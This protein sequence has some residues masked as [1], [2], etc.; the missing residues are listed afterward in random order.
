VSRHSRRTAPLDSKLGVLATYDEQEPHLIA[1]EWRG[2]VWVFAQA[3]D[4]RPLTDIAILELHDAMFAPL[5]DWAGRP[6]TKDVGPGG[7]VEVPFARVR[8]ELR[9]LGD[10]FDTWRAAIGEDPTLEQIAGVVA[11]AHHRFQWI[12]PFLDTNGRTGRVLDLFVL[13]SSF[14]LASGSMETSPVI[15]YFPDGDREDGYYRGLLEADL[16][17]PGNAK[18]TLDRVRGELAAEEQSSP[19]QSAQAIW[20][21]GYAAYN[22]GRYDEA[23]R[24]YQQA[25]KMDPSFAPALNSL[26]RIAFAE[27]DL[28][29]AERYFREAIA[30]Q[31][32][33]VP[34][35]DKLAR[36]ELT[37]GHYA[38]AERLAAEGVRLR[39]GY[40][41]AETLLKEIQAR[42]APSPD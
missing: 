3:T 11:D 42:S 23:Q 5:L 25:L 28:A 34:A 19:T 18:A 20:S 31:A 41:P 6:R 1:A 24:H 9:K 38:E 26:G 22:A 40:A 36:I 14:G 7:K 30:K 8:E 17:R 39:P 35:L 13:W 27:K 12:H 37:R 21:K 16:H 33:Y 32:D 4:R 15:E 10:D 29:T 2:R